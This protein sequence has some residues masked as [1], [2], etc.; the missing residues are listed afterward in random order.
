MNFL[1]YLNPST[2]P[3]RQQSPNQGRNFGYPDCFTAWN[4][5]EIPNFHGSVGTQF[6]LGENSTD[7]DTAC[8]NNYVAPRLTFQPHMAPLDIKFNTE[9]TEAWV[10]WHGSWDRTNPVGYKVGS[11]RF[12]NGSPVEDPSSM[13]ALTDIVTNQDNSQCPEHCFRPAGLAWDSEGR[14]F[15]SSDSTGEI[16]V[17]TKSGGSPNVNDATPSP[18]S[19]APSPPASSTTTSGGVQ[20]RRVSVSVFGWVLGLAI[21]LM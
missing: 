10:S 2:A 6:S 14:L 4:T 18:S 15:F 16:Y 12:A 7:N 21:L 20:D 13:T 11:V 5:S 17:I 1:G 3:N 19:A 9:G 8:T